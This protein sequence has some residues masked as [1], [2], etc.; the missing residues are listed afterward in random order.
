M[1]MLDRDGTTLAL[2]R[3]TSLAGRIA[4]AVVRL[5][6][7]STRPHPPVQGMGKAAQVASLYSSSAG[8]TSHRHVLREASE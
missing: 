1:L 2:E 6:A 7:W 4:D 8:A 5:G 3:N